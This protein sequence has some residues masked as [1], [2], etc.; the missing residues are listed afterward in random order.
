MKIAEKI[1]RKN[2][3]DHKIELLREKRNRK[4]SVLGGI[5]LKCVSKSNIIEKSKIKSERKQGGMYNFR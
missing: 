2:P 5:K 1:R 4:M 3:R